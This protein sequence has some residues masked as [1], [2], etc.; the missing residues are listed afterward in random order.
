MPNNRNAQP[1][2]RPQVQIESTGAMGQPVVK[3]VS[4]QSNRL[5]VKV[6]SL[7]QFANALAMPSR[8]LFADFALWTAAIA[9]LIRLPLSLAAAG[10]LP[11]WG[12]LLAWLLSGL[13]LGF[14]LAMVWAS[15]P[16]QRVDVVYRVVQVVLATAIATN[17]LWLI[18]GVS[19]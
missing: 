5:A 14:A 7:E 13:P 11:L 4:L 19:P 8:G 12:C 10:V 16:D 1:A 18:E 9:T 6:D 15:V 2:D 3:Q 17:F